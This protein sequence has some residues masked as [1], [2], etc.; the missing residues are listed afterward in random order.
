M[1]TKKALNATWRPRKKKS[2]YSST[3]KPKPVVEKTVAVPTENPP[4]PKNV[5]QI[6]REKLEHDP[7]AWGLLFLPE[8]LRDKPARFHL[9]IMDAA[10]KH[11]KLAIVAPRGHSKST[12]LSFVYPLHRIFY[13]KKRFIVLFS[14][15]KEKAANFLD[16]IKVELE[17]NELLHVVYGKPEFLK[18]SQYDM[19]IRFKGSHQIR[20]V[21]RG[22]D[23]IQNIRG[24]IK[25]AWRPDLMIF[26]DVE[27]QDLVN[28][29]DRRRKLKQ[30]F[31]EAALPAGDIKTCQYI[32]IGTILH[33]D[34]LIANL[35]SKDQYTKWHKLFYV[36]VIDESKKRV[37]WEDRVPF[38][39]LMDIKKDQPLVYAKEYQNNPVSGENTRFSIEMFRYYEETQ[40]GFTLYGH[41][42]EIVERC[43]WYDCVPAIGCDLA[44][45]E[46]K[47]ADESVILSS[48]LTPLG[49]L[50]IYNYVNERGMRPQRFRNILF[51]QVK[52]LKEKTTILPKVGMEKAM[53]ERVN[54]ELLKLEM[55]K[56]RFFFVLKDLKWEHDKISRI[57]VGL[58]GRY[59]NGA[60]FHKHGMGELEEQLLHFPYGKHDDIIDAEQ[61]S[62]QLLKFSR[63]NS[64]NNYTQDE[65]DPTFTYWHKQLRSRRRNSGN[66]DPKGLYLFGRKSRD[67]IHSQSAPPM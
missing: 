14:N 58:E 27:Y 56:R 39:Y 23:G 47:T 38:D 2:K 19:I 6:Y 31:R 57:E 35:V 37:L 1:S 49:N 64:K 36:A 21:S 32:A 40:G 8:H 30:D 33:F 41:N 42:K 45:S 52:F 55:R 10:V 43:N 5:Y 20:I 67:T 16:R 12:I 11:D 29:A 54:T 44:W 46:K 59:A 51:E 34:A 60:V 63:K 17:T 15:T 3:S 28:S 24:E 53:L 62:F 50:L 7:L 61:G 9:E 18:S 4:P 26:D 66:L 13:Q 25:G 65:D 22:E 48:I